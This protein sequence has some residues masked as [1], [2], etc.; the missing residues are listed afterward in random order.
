MGNMELLDD[1][2]AAI[3]RIAEKYGVYDIRIFGSYAR[4]AAVAASD[5]DLLVKIQKG[6]SY[7]DLIGF[8]QDVQ[9]LLGQKVDVISEGGISPYLEDRILSEAIPL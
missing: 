1:Q 5:L 2:R 3:R 8:W 6:R 4:G 9:D 7:L